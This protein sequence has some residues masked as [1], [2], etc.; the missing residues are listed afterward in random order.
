MR[1]HPHLLT[2]SFPPVLSSSTQ[3]H[4]LRPQHE[5]FPTYLRH[6]FSAVLAQ[7]Q[8]GL[9]GWVLDPAAVEFCARKVGRGGGWGGVG[10]VG[11]W[12]GGG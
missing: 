1:G 7:R 4:N 8:A 9:P 11:V 2:P 5:L 10:Q 6:Q 3:R 12:V